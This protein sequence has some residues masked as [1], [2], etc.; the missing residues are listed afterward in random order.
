MA[1]SRKSHELWHGHLFLNHLYKN[2]HH[3]THYKP[4]HYIYD[5]GVFCS[6]ISSCIAMNRSF[7]IHLVLC[8]WPCYPAPFPN[9]QTQKK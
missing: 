4:L 6:S 2:H 5:S 7:R 1:T 3:R 9:D 8:P